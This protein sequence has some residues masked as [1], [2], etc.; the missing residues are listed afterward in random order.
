MTALSP[1]ETQVM[2]L[3]AEGKSYKAIAAALCICPN[4]VKV[5]LYNARRKLLAVNNPNAVAIVITLKIVALAN[6]QSVEG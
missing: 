3:M 2:Q 6:Y 5:H 4:T 1:R